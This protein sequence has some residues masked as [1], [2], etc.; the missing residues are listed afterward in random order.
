MKVIYS[1]NRMGTVIDARN[2]VNTGRT[3]HF[4]VKPQLWI[5]LKWQ[6]RK[7]RSM[8]SIGLGTIV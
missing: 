2:A 4:L 7:N 5:L 1:Q 3:L 6:M 8:N